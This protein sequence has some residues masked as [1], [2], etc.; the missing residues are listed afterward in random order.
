MPILDVSEL[1]IVLSVLGE[2]ERSEWD[3]SSRRPTIS[4]EYLHPSLE[5]YN[6]V[7]WQDLLTPIL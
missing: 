2:Y 1:N 6:E 4:V 5:V 3:D 7:S